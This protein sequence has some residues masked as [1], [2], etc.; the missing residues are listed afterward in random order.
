MSSDELLYDFFVLTGS[1]FF[2]FFPF[3]GRHLHHMEVP[4][5]GAELQLQLLTYTTATTT[6]DPSHICDL[7]HSLQRH[8]IL[9]PWSEARDGT[10]ILM[11]TN[12]VLNPMSHNRNSLT[13]SFQSRTG[14]GSIWR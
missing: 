7:H 12:L 3:L 4:R 1:F 11:D 8:W 6:Q 10:H 13:A 5:I 2:F 9:N 14:V